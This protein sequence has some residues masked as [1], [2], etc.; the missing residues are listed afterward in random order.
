M[1]EEQLQIIL[2]R[3]DQ[4]DARFDRLERR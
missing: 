4:V 3:F 2:A 1:S